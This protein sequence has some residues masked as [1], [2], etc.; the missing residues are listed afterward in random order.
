MLAGSA[1]IFLAT[2]VVLVLAWRRPAALGA[3]APR[4]L[5]L[6]GGLVLPSAIL[7]ALVIAAFVLGERL[8]GRDGSPS[9]LRIEAEGRQWMWT[10]SYPEAGNLVSRGVLHLPVGRAVEVAVTSADVIH[11]F[12]VP[13][14]GGKIDAIPGHRNVIRLLAEKPGTYGGACAEFCGSGHGAM[15]F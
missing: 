13:R 14:L 12:W 3:D 11:S 8:I 2:S 10:F 4:L 15:R 1:L 6:W 9:T 5:M 7:A